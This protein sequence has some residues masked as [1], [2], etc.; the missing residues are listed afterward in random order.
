MRKTEN[1]LAQDRY[2]TA[3]GEPRGLPFIKV[4]RKILYAR[5]DVLAY[6]AAG[7]TDPEDVEEV[8]A[9]TRKLARALL[10]AAGKSRRGA[11]P[12]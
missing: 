9:E 1:S 8:S 11:G 3:R 12:P 7:R 4:G 5:V 10:D 6:L 2:L